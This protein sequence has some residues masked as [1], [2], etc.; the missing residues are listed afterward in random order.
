MKHRVTVTNNH[1]CMI[2]GAIEIE[3]VSV[4]PI[5]FCIACYQSE[6]LSAEELHKKYIH[7]YKL[8]SFGVMYDCSLNDIHAAVS[9][10]AEEATEIVARWKDGDQSL[11]T[12]E[13][14]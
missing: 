8:Q 11:G 10:T 2:C 9:L 12:R 14:R 13:D 5:T 3:M 7:I 4:Y 1:W 6:N